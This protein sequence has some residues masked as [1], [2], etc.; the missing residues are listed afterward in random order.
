M[1]SGRCHT[2]VELKAQ[3]EERKKGGRGPGSSEWSGWGPQTPPGA[4]VCPF[5]KHLF[6]LP[7]EAIWA[8]HWNPASSRSLPCPRRPPVLCSHST[9]TGRLALPLM[10]AMILMTVSNQLLNETGS[11][12]KWQTVFF[13]SAHLTAPGRVLHRH[14]LSR[15]TLRSYNRLRLHSSSP[16][17][18]H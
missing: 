15:S 2:S 6:W 8:L 9:P 10:P 7:S 4:P 1:E 18:K 14:G 12:S 5:G 17:A 11:I 13:I 3:S 16:T